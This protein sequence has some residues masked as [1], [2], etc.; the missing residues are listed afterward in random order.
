MVTSTRALK[1]S[2]C[3]ENSL[4]YVLVMEIFAVR[5]GVKEGERDVN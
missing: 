4:I 2:I 5:I 1:I 3:K